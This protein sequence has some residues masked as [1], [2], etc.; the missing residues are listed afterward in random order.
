MSSNWGYLL[1]VWVLT[2]SMEFPMKHRNRENCL[3]RLNGQQW[4]CRTDKKE[5]SPCRMDPHKTRPEWIREAMRERSVLTRS[6][7]DKI[8]KQVFACEL[9]RDQENVTALTNYVINNMT[10][11]SDH[12]SGVSVSHHIQKCLST[13]MLDCRCLRGCTENRADEAEE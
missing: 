8:H 4:D 7:E 5:V 11:P 10:N 13:Y 3:Q 6:S 1:C 9:K 12:E 2:L